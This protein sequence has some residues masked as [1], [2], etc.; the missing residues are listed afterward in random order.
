M[1]GRTGRVRAASNAVVRSVVVV[2]SLASAA[3]SFVVRPS[4][5]DARDVTTD[6]TRDALVDGAAF[7]EA[8]ADAIVDA[9][10]QDADF[11]ASDRVCEWGPPFGWRSETRVTSRTA[12][13]RCPASVEVRG[14]PGSL[15]CGGFEACCDYPASCRFRATVIFEDSRPHPC[16]GRPPCYPPHVREGYDCRC[17]RGTIRCEPSGVLPFAICSDCYV[18]RSMCSDSGPAG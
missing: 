8:D 10:E 4:S 3:C 1:M 13:L 15:D 17:E 5:D 16:T 11:D 14:S 9:S 7:D 18:L 12:D 2:S 6:A